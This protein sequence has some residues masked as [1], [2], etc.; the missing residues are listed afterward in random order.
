M[1]KKHNMVWGAVFQRHTAFVFRRL[2]ENGGGMCIQNRIH[3]RWFGVC[4]EGY[5]FNGF[6]IEMMS[7]NGG[8]MGLVWNSSFGSML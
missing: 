1:V 4:V 6:Q 5:N 3:T 2:S 7:W 8:R